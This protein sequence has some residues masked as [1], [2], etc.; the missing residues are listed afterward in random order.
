MLFLNDTQD[1][2][3]VVL[4]DEEVVH[5]NLFAFLFTLS[6]KKYFVCETNLIYL[7]RGERETSPR[8]LERLLEETHEPSPTSTEFGGGIPLD[9]ISLNTSSRRRGSG[10][11]NRRGSGDRDSPVPGGAP[12]LNA[13]ARE[14]KHQIRSLGQQNSLD[15]SGN[16]NERMSSSSST[17]NIPV[18]TFRPRED[19]LNDTELSTGSAAVNR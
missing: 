4:V 7:G 18:G 10:H 15:I 12:F 1:C 19:S 14:L 16:N 5:V 6:T 13:A 2:S 9:E 8:V 11:R 3:P 17:R